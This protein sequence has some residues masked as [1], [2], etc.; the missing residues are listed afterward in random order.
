ME[1][2]SAGNSHPQK[3]IDWRTISAV[4]RQDISCP[5]HRTPRQK[6]NP[7]EHSQISLQK[8][9][10]FKSFVT[11]I[12]L[13]I[14]QELVTSSFSTQSRESQLGSNFHASTQIWSSHNQTCMLER[15]CLSW[16]R[17][18]HHAQLHAASS[19]CLRI[20][21]PVIAAWLW[22]WALDCRF[23]TQPYLQRFVRL[24]PF[25]EWSPTGCAVHPIYLY[26]SPGN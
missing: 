7:I 20:S 16:C 22:E 21:S 17:K 12:P 23:S 6:N 13:P 1:K 14:N 2:K 24:L 11:L 18:C 5:A 25:E 26:D 8:P 15:S 9:T 10:S 4:K 19:Y 3:W